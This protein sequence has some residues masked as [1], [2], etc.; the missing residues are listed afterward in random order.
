MRFVT[1]FIC[2]LFFVACDESADPSAPQGADPAAVNPCDEPMPG[3]RCPGGL[4][5]D[6]E[7][8]PQD[9][10]DL[11]FGGMVSRCESEGEKTCAYRVS[12]ANPSCAGFCETHNMVCVGAWE[13]GEDACE[14]ADPVDCDAEIYEYNCQCEWSD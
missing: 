12:D 2:A 13:R 1:L 14:I 9:P 5:I 11:E 4:C 3:G 6:G 7:C 8:I 10:C